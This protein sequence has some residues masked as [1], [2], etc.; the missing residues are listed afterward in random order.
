MNTSSESRITPAPGPTLARRPTLLTLPFEL[1][2][3]ILEVCFLGSEVHYEQ[4]SWSDWE[5]FFNPPKHHILLT[6]KQLYNDGVSIYYQ[7]TTLVTEHSKLQARKTP[8]P[9]GHTSNVQHIRFDGTQFRP[10]T[11]WNDFPIS[12]LKPFIALKSIKFPRCA[13]YVEQ[14]TETVSDLRIWASTTHP[15]LVIRRQIDAAEKIIAAFPETTVFFDC[16][17]TGQTLRLV[18]CTPPALTKEVQQSHMPTRVRNV[19]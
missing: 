16:A 11:L 10:S 14:M 15:D 13:T 2:K 1:R 18:S 3:A 8:L 5:L 7:H 19:L 4:T 12:I 9:E 6:C 17:V